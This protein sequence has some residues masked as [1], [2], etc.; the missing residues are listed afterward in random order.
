MEH[1]I[2]ASSF[3][4]RHPA[5]TKNC[6]WWFSFLVQICQ[7]SGENFECCSCLTP[8]RSLPV[9]RYYSMSAPSSTQDWG[10]MGPSVFGLR[11]QTFMPLI[12]SFLRCGGKPL[13]G[14]A[15]ESS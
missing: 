10:L 6:V 14:R 12:L 8:G 9:L 11:D 2:E 15:L 3:R 4:G 7:L 13:L 5:R 1:L